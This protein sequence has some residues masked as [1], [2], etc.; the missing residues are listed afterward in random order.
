[1]LY[2]PRQFHQQK[3]QGVSFK[4]STAISAEEAEI[5]YFVIINIVDFNAKIWQVYRG[6]QLLGG[7]RA[8]VSLLS[9]VAS[10]IT[11]PT[12]QD[13]LPIKPSPTR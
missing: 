12:L 4:G 6:C 2:R 1:M 5:F 11:L 9:S 3:C 10:I 7:K 8:N 13:R